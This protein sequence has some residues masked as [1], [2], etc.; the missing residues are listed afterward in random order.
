MENQSSKHEEG[1]LIL[2]LDVP[3][4]S[5]QIHYLQRSILDVIETA[6]SNKGADLH[7]GTIYYLNNILRATCEHVYHVSDYAQPI[8]KNMKF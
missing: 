7:K 3:N 2:D 5:E 4:T 6:S 8:A 1:N